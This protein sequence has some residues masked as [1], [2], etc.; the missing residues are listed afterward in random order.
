MMRTFLLLLTFCISLQIASAQEVLFRVLV[1]SNNLRTGQVSETEVFQDLQNALGK[2]LNDQKWT[3][4]R[5][6]EYERIECDLTITLTESPS[7][8]VFRGTAQILTRRPILNTSYQSTLL[9][10]A[11]RDFNF[12]YITAQ[13][14]IYGQN[15]F[16]D[17]LTSMLAFYVYASLAMDYDS[18]SLLGGDPFVERALEIVNIAQQSPETGWR[19]NQSTNNRFWISENLNSQQLIPFREAIYKYH[20]LGLDQFQINPDSARASV[21][22]ALKDIDEVNKIKP[23]AVLVSIFFDAKFQEIIYI[24]EKASAEIRQEVFALVTKIDPGHTEKYETLVK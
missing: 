6:E 4:D 23:S 17:N 11:D 7:Q 22:E 2:F 14:L 1:N 18:F 5:F 21:L 12:R 13:P 20:R 16:N 19:R 24:F 9:S 15:V 3:N 10:Y 8:N